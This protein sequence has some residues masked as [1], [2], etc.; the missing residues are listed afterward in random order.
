MAES[1]SFKLPAGSKKYVQHNKCHDWKK[2]A[3]VL[4][5]TSFAAPAIRTATHTKILHKIPEINAVPKSKD[6]LPM[7][8]LIVNAPRRPL[9]NPS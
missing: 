7:A 5:A 2:H 4:P 8:I 3:K 6:T 9:V 1:L